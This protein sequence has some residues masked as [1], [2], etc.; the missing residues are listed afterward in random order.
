MTRPASNSATLREQAAAGVLT[1][2]SPAPLGWATNRR[3]SSAC[4]QRRGHRRVLGRTPRT[5]SPKVGVIVGPPVPSTQ[6]VR[7]GSVASKRLRAMDGTR[8]AF[9]VAGTR[10]AW[11][12][13]MRT[14]PRVERPGK[15]ATS[16]PR[17]RLVR[18]SSIWAAR[19]RR[20][21]AKS[22]STLAEIGAPATG[23]DPC[24]I[25]PERGVAALAAKPGSTEK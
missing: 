13:K 4:A 14:G 12:E 8:S 5:P 6:A 2:P 10:D 17:G 7:T 23:H 9:G 15:A 11:N 24:E 18:W 19:R 25:G 20:H 3:A 21:V 1:S 22:A 16:R